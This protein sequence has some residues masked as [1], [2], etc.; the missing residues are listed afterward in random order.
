MKHSRDAIQKRVTRLDVVGLDVAPSD[1]HAQRGSRLGI[2]PRCGREARET[3]A[4]LAAVALR[5]VEGAGAERASKLLTQ[6][7]VV[8]TDLGHRV[9]MDFDGADSEVQNEETW[10]VRWCTPRATSSGC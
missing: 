5:D 8:V 4:A 1:R 2:G 6:I 7:A 9:A 10:G 3:M